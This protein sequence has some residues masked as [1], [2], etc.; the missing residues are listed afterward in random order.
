MKGGLRTIKIKP[1]I[2]QYIKE[3][4]NSAYD[5]LAIEF[6]YHNND[7]ENLGYTHKEIQEIVQELK[8]SGSHG[9]YETYMVLNMKDVFDYMIDTLGKPI[10]GD[11][12]LSMHSI[13]ADK[14]KEDHQGFKGCWKKLPNGIMGSDITFVEPED[15]ERE[16]QKLLE[17]WNASEKT[18]DDIIDFHIQFEYIHPYAFGNGI[19][20]RLLMLK[21]CIEQ[22]H[23][24]I[25]IDGKHYGDYMQ[26]LYVAQMLG[27]ASQLK[28]MIPICQKE[29]EGRLSA[30]AHTVDSI[31]WNRVLNDEIC[32]KV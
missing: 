9:V 30:L 2:I 17:R 25:I 12:L 32:M 21:Q 6:M 7:L 19:I 1:E 11:M 29:M 5:S 28:E 26:G 14:T 24:L 15:V 8:L 4:P 18:M 22:E 10:H 13:L 27:D 3:A 31:D 20:G 23:D 16:L